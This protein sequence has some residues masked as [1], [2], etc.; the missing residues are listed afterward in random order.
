MSLL[1]SD[2]SLVVSEKFT[3]GPLSYEFAPGTT[4]IVGR[5]GSGKST[6]FRL[7][8]GSEDAENG[9]ATWQGETIYTENHQYKKRIGFL[10]QPLELPLW[11]SAKHLLEYIA[12]L[13]GMDNPKKRQEKITHI[14]RLWQVDQFYTKPLKS[15]SYG[16]RKRVALGLALLDDPELLILDE[17]LSGLDVSHITTLRQILKSRTERGLTTI[18]STHILSFAAEEAQN[19]LFMSDGQWQIPPRWPHLSVAE[20]GDILRSFFHVSNKAE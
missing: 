8:T 11:T 10:P 16:M 2:L 4:M 19:I 17:P 5:N 14:T 15:C 12:L 3:L 1:L 9:T 20:R 18:L 7:I 6:L 13:R